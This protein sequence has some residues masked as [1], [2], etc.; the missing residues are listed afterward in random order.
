M[1]DIRKP[2]LLC[3]AGSPLAMDAAI[4]G[5]ADAVYMGGRLFN[6]RILAKNFTDQELAEAI[7]KAHSYGTK[8]YITLNTLIYDREMSE[9]LRAAENIYRCSADG[10]IIADIGAAAVL[11]RYLPELPLHASTQMSGH[12]AD[13][14]RFLSRLGY[15]RMVL[16][17]EMS[18]SDIGEFT[19]NSP[20]EA[21]VFVHG[22]ICVS[23][24][25]QCLFSSAV[26]QRSGNRGEC[27]QPCRLPYYVC[28][29]S[30]Y[31]LSLK[32]LSLARHVPELIDAGVA[33]FK[34]EGRMK[35]P[36]YIR[37][38]SSVWRRLIDEKRSASDE[39]MDYLAR[40]FSRSGF[41]DSYFVGNVASDGHSMLGV[42]SDSDKQSTRMLEP[43][44]RIRRKIGVDAAAVIE[45]DKPMKLTLFDE[46]KSVTVFG[47]TPM[48]AQK[49]PIDKETVLRSIS[50]TGETPYEIKNADITLGDGLMVPVSWLN[51][52]R[53]SAFDA[54]GRQNGVCVRSLDGS[55]EY[56]PLPKG[57]RLSRAAR[58][59]RSSA[60]F[61]SAAQITSKAKEY[62][63]SVF[64]PLQNYDAVADG[65]VM[66]PVIFDSERA[67]VL[68]MLKSAK[69]KGARYA[70]VGNI[71]HTDICDEAKLIRLGDY[72]L[73]IYNRESVEAYGKEGFGEML[74]SP[75]LTL[76]QIRDIGRNTAV[77]VYGR[78]PLMTLEKCVI[79]EI[80]DCEKCRSSSAVLKDRRGIEFPVLREWEHRSII[81]N[82]VPVYM[83][84]RQDV[85]SDNGIMSRH[86]IFSAESPE[87]VDQVIEAYRSK[88]APGDDGTR[89]TSKGVKRILG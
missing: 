53:R 79:K 64:L 30:K 72:R 35:S 6:A 50:K 67:A 17:R 24:S 85:L 38:V 51:A 80:A 73:N 55:L 47:Q 76:P 26:G 39:E 15:T 11:H 16:A 12:S 10:V 62:F 78:L 89:F 41:T 21:E 82:S 65:V 75:E 71:G 46:T 52:L 34:I 23:H 57:K 60:R 2:E 43:F 1:L 18:Y 8:V 32:D 25:G 59:V 68:D 45:A 83:A 86:F 9:L 33:S 28:G 69:A 54:F 49:A 58:A 61:Y 56:E 4:D 70:L 84:D 77:I 44:D 14:A 87:E 5:G 36:E 13:A 7:A 31:P 29:Q 22:A 40:I 19:K 88:K 48:A 3:P 66:P 63:D 27:A 37:E 74:L 81:Y 20:I 42:R